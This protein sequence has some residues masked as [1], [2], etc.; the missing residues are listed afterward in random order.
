MCM[1]SFQMVRGLLWEPKPT[2]EY[3]LA[4]VVICQLPRSLSLLLQECLKGEAIGQSAGAAHAQ[5]PS[6]T[7]LYDRQSAFRAG[8]AV[9][10]PAGK[11]VRSGRYQNLTR[12]AFT[13]KRL[14]VNV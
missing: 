14:G 1:E 4:L 13:R 7:P 6:Q 10:G 12:F 8:E 9:F 2:A 11:E 3:W 5:I